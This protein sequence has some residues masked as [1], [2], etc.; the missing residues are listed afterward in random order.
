MGKIKDDNHGTWEIADVGVDRCID[1]LEKTGNVAMLGA[2]RGILWELRRKSIHQTTC[3]EVGC[4]PLAHGAF[5]SYFRT[6]QKLGAGLGL[7][8]K[9]K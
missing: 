3:Q 5:K 7:Q 6:I 8:W 2:L 9:R 4:F 1:W